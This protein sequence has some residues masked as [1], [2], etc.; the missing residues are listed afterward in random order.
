MPHYPLANPAFG[1]TQAF[2]AGAVRFLHTDLRFNKT[3]GADGPRT[4]LGPLQKQWLLAELSRAGDYDLVV[5]AS[6][7]PWIAPP[8]AQSD[9]WGAYEPERREIANAIRDMEVRNLCMISG[10]AHML[11]IDDGSNNR[12]SSDGRGGFPVFHAAAL[13]SK[14]SQKGGRYSIG[15]EDGTAGAG[16][17]DKRQYGICEVTYQRDGAGRPVGSPNVTWVG[18]RAGKDGTSQPRVT[19]VMRHQFPAAQTYSGF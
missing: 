17:A 9:H 15:Q 19:D 7:F 6:S 18:R 14:P 4:V 13:D 16:V 11:A 3:S 1:V 2:T 8:D 10:D 5:W 12:F